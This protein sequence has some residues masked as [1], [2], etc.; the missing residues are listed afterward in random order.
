MRLGDTVLL[1]RLVIKKFRSIK[2]AD[3]W[4][5]NLNAIVG[6]NNSGKSCLLRAL[7][8]FFNFEKEKAAFDAGLHLYAN[9]TVSKIEVHLTDVND[10]DIPAKFRSGN[11]IVVE[12]SYR[13]SALGCSRTVR[14]RAGGSWVEDEEV[15]ASLLQ[16]VGFILIPPNRDADQLTRIEE[17]VFGQ[18]VEERMSKATENRD[19]YSSRFRT[20][21]QYLENN[22]LARLAQDANSSFPISH[23]IRLSI[24]YRG[25]ISYSNFLS[26]FGVYVDEEGLTHPL[27]EC[28]SG[29]Q[30][31]AI[32]ALYNQLA[33]LR[34]KKIIVGL[35]EPETNLHPQAQKELLDYFKS[36]IEE[37]SVSQF[38]FTTHSSVMIDQVDHT[39]VILF[40]KKSDDTR[41]FL[42]EVRRL[43]RDFYDVY[44]LNEFKYYQFYGYRN[45]EFFF[46]RYIVVTESK[47]EIEVIQKIGE[48]SGVEY[49][50]NGL[51]YLSLDGVDNSVYAFALLNELEIPYLLVVDKD[52]FF[53]YLNDEVMNSRDAQG[54]P[55]FR[56]ELKDEDLISYKV[57]ERADRAQLANYANANHT[58]M[59]DLLDNYDVVSMRFNLEIDL[60]AAEAAR[61]Y[62]YNYFNLVPTE[63]TTVF[64]LTQ[65]R[66]AI[67]KVDTILRIM[68]HIEPA[69]WPR[70]FSRIKR[71]MNSAAA[72]L[73]VG[74]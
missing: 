62:L 45:S 43:R 41:G 58:G 18:L 47:T 50:V 3:I 13:L 60:V 52:F 53:P 64:L 19:N 70:S 49:D 48:K 42:S 14:Y 46:S 12:A 28:G 71:A 20:A 9:G 7:N 74:T 5:G 34:N 31:L 73:A 66:K 27:S 26:D 55:Q 59:L 1:D 2:K 61:N 33:T 37:G 67:K 6:Q 15:F 16:H 29:I 56:A 23:P 40:W 4:I 22:A 17:S 57:S 10:T 44:G 32:I 68:D 36:T 51:T 35:E 54:F 63:R 69:S 8:A 39:E 65:R 25:E 30:S 38:F 11:R 24:G 21:V 72:D